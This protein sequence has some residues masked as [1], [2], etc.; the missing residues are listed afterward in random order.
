MKKVIF[1][2]YTCNE[3]HETSSKTLI[4]V[5][6]TK[7]KAISMIKRHA[8]GIDDCQLCP[9]DINNLERIN[10]TQGYEG[11]NEFMIEP[12]EIDSFV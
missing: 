2:V 12:F 5:A 7:D 1:L 6:S 3:W 8:A 4:A 9:D 11:G 10:Q